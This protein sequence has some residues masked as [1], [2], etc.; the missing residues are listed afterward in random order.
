VEKENY[1]Y[2]FKSVVWPSLSHS[3]M[4]FNFYVHP[5]FS[6]KPSANLLNG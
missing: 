3:H 1:Y 5:P 2:C 4:Y 6:V